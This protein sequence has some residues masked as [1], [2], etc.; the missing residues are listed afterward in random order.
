MK[1]TTDICPIW[2]APYRANVRNDGFRKLVISSRVGGAYIITR[3][4]EIVAQKMDGLRKSILTSWLVDQRLR[5]TE[6]PSITIEDVKHIERK[7]P[8]PVHERADRLLRLIAKQAG[9]VGTNVGFY[10]SDPVVLAWSESISGSE[11]LFLLQ[12]LEKNIW[13]IGTEYGDGFTGVVTVEGHGHIAD[14]ETNTDSSHE[15]ELRSPVLSNV[16]INREGTEVQEYDFFISHAS[17]D[18]DGFVRPLAKILS[19]LGAKVW[20]DEFALKVGDSL[21]REIDIGLANSRFGIV[22]LSENFFKKAWPQRELDGL[23]ALETQSQNRILPIWYE[24]SKDEVARYSPM[25][26]DIIALDTSVKTI[27][28]ISNELMS[29]IQ[30]N[31]SVD[32]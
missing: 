5:G 24:V 17:E 14:L 21:R 11:V 4:A 6:I 32:T 2:G 25:L 30:A 19:E 15:P 22:V 28:G 1:T 3:E 18:K 12:Y 8:L 7:H 10:Y 20:F 31:D 23:V 29:R 27:A 26:A 9:A 16:P 13:I